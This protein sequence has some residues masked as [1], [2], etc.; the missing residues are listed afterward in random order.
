MDT[1]DMYGSF[2]KQ[3]HIS[4]RPSCLSAE[5][6]K[7]CSLRYCTFG[8]DWFRSGSYHHFKFFNLEL[9]EVLEHYVYNISVPLRQESDPNQLSNKTSEYKVKPGIRLQCTI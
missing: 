6:L 8:F 3:R 9:R 5:V 4:F 7:A 1:I 2:N